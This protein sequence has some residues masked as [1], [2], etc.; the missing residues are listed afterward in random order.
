MLSIR[1][2]D[3]RLQLARSGSLLA[4]GIAQGAEISS[5]PIIGL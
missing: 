4:A 1:F 3:L 5:T 2:G